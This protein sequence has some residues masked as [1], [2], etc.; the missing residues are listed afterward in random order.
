M[1]CR[2]LLSLVCLL[3]L[4]TAQA[5]SG[6]DDLLDVTITKTV[7]ETVTKYLSECG[8]GQTDTYTTDSTLYGTTT[9]TSTFQTTISTIVSSNR[10][11]ASGALPTGIDPSQSDS[12]FSLP[13][14][15]LTSIYTGLNHSTA[16]ANPTAKTPC[17]TTTVVVPAAVTTDALSLS[18]SHGVHSV[19]SV[20]STSSTAATTV[21]PSQIPISGSAIRVG[22]S[23]SGLGAAG[24]IFLLAAGF[25]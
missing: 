11:D 13:S 7:T 6:G 23:R 9:V 25:L 5:Y 22:V 17:S 2:W 21:S 15:S 1:A 20:H 8:A 12:D 14:S 3:A 16:T 10:T 19:T 4:T 24:F 18:T